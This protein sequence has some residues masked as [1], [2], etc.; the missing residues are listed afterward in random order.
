L[1]GTTKYGSSSLE[2]LYSV[3]RIS[4]LCVAWQVP[5]SGRFIT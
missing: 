5:H 4:S 3:H 1:N 2:N